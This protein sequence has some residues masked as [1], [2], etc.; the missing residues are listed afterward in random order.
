MTIKISILVLFLCCNAILAQY[1]CTIKGRVISISTEKPLKNVNV[2]IAGTT[3]GT[4]TNDSGSYKISNVPSGSHNIV[5]S[6]VGFKP[7]AVNISLNEG[8]SVD[9]QFNLRDYSYELKKVEITA[10]VPGDWKNSLEE[11]KEYFLGDSPFAAECKIINP[12]IIN[13]TKLKSGELKADASQPI[14]VDNNA[15]GYRIFC[16]LVY[17]DWTP[18]NHNLRYVV[19]SYFTELEDSTGE[20]KKVWE[21]NR[22]IAYKGSQVH[23]IRSM[24]NNSLYENDFF[25]SIDRSLEISENQSIPTEKPEI[26]KLP[27]NKIKINFEK[28]LRIEF[29]PYRKRDLKVSWMKLNHPNVIFDKY[30]YPVENF[31]YEV[32]GYWAFKGISFTLPNYY[33]P[34][35][36]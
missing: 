10:E 3:L 14:I 1:T 24:I 15:L 9:I 33:Y 31:S 32:Y 2:Y 35:D 12:E 36:K 34:K 18:K 8:S 22:I 23:F 20:L 16:N 29:K 6:A 4:T 30:G 13:F 17:F 19:D 27:G 5:A 11:F 26:K 28:Y 21:K 7:G 25:I